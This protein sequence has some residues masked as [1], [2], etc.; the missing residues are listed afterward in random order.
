[1]LMIYDNFLDN[2]SLM[3]PNNLRS[4]NIGL[5]FVASR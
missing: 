4:S 5:L 1:M 2:S 3:S